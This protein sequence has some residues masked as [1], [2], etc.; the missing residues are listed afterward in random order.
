M[1]SIGFV[2]GLVVGLFFA[3]LAIITG[4]AVVLLTPMDGL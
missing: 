2:M 1:D 4:M 3:A